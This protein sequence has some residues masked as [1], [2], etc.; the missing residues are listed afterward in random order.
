V[1]LPKT[2]KIDFGMGQE[3]APEWDRLSARY[4]PGIRPEARPFPWADP[5]SR[6]AMREA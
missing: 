6:K 3:D 4:D 5:G 2:G 1:L